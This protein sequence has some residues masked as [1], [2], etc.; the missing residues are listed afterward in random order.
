MYHV[1]TRGVDGTRVVRDDEDA[2]AFLQLMV[3][4]VTRFHWTMHALCLMPNHYHVV[5]ETT[6]AKLSRGCHRLNGVYA[7]RFNKKHGRRGHL[8]GDRFWASIVETEAHMHNACEYV[9][10]NPVRA[11]LCTAAADWPWTGCRYGLELS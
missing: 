8:F 1:T 9:I 11:G 7:Q 5:V 3:A 4:V 2:L 10:A 6:L